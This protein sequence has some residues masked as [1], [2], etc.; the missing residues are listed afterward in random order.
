MSR[1]YDYVIIDGAPQVAEMAALAT[2]ISDMVIIPVQP[3]PYDVWACVDLV[4]VI[5]TRQLVTDG[6]PKAAFLISMAIVNTNLANEI[7][8][9]IKAYELPILEHCTHRTVLYPET[10]KIGGSVITVK[11][12]G[13]SHP[14]AKDIENITNE[15]LEMLHEQ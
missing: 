11:K 1:G 4:D 10:A 7:K 5:K 14:A 3:S 13:E 9:I 2:S 12:Q 15:I 8:D 6:N